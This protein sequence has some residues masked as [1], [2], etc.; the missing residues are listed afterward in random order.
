MNSVASTFFEEINNLPEDEI[1]ISFENIIFISRSF[2]QEYFIQKN[3]TEKI[4]TEINIPEEVSPI[5]EI[6][7]RSFKIGGI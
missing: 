4:I 3:K 6:V 5:L 7:E 1:K 2:A